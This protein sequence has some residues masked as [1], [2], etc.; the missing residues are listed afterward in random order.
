MLIGSDSC[1][2][3][4]K[5][6]GKMIKT[7]IMAPSIGVDLSREERQGKCRV[8]YNYFLDIINIIER[9]IS[10]IASSRLISNFKEINLLM[11]T[12]E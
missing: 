12:I 5:Q 11:K 10:L 4:F 9:K 8:C 3:I 6:F 7:S 2:I 1:K